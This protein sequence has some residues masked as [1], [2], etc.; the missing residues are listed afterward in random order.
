MLL[1]LAS[2]FLPY[3]LTAADFFALEAVAAGC[4]SKLLIKLIDSLFS[5]SM[6]SFAAPIDGFTGVW[7]GLSCSLSSYLFLGVDG[8]EGPSVRAPIAA[9][10]G[11]V[12]V[13]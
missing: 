10:I 2:L 7:F 9:M 8:F 12:P 6:P 1:A 11:L 4:A 5:I 13:L 3:L